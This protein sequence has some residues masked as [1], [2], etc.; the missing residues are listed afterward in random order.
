MSEVR[1]LSGVPAS[2]AIAVATAVA[3]AVRL[4]ERVA[5]GEKVSQ[6]EWVDATCALIESVPATIAADESGSAGGPR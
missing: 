5:G 1:I 6:R 4:L 2:N 3:T